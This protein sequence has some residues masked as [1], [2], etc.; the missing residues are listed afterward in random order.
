MLLIQI[1]SFF[2]RNPP[3]NPHHLEMF[4][5]LILDNITLYSSHLTRLVSWGLTSIKS[6]TL[7]SLNGVYG[8]HVFWP[9]IR[10]LNWIFYVNNIHNNWQWNLGIYNWTSNCLKAKSP[11]KE[12]HFEGVMV[13]KNATIYLPNIPCMASSSFHMSNFVQFQPSRNPCIWI[14]QHLWIFFSI[15]LDTSLPQIKQ[16]GIGLG[17]PICSLGDPSRLTFHS[18]IGGAFIGLQTRF[19]GETLY[20]IIGHLN[21]PTKNLNICISICLTKV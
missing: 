18:F 17:T 13:L 8:S 2:H 3:L 19:M 4:I 20:C 11:P 14:I 7:K 21:K 15:D 10:K 5:L 6:P 9:V 1:W 12:L 16:Y